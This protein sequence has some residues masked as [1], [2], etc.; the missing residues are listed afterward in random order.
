MNMPG[1]G[2]DQDTGMMSADDMAALG[3]AQ[4]V[5]ATTLFLTQMT[6]HPTAAIT[7]PGP[8]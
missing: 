4:G 6:E 1:A 5:D 7:R 8:R 2:G 3:D